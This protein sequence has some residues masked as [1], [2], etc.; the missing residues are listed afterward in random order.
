[1]KKTPTRVPTSIP[2]APVLPMVRFPIAP[3]PVAKTSGMS[4]AM[5]AKEVI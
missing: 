1:M 4:P 3:A 5:K 2:P